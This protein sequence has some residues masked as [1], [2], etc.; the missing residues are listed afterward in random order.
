VANT[1][2]PDASYRPREVKEIIGVDN[3]DTVYGMLASGQLRGFR[4]G[5]GKAWRIAA[6]ALDEYMA[7]TAKPLVDP[8][9]AEIIA[10][11]PPLTD[12]QVDAIV[13]IIQADRS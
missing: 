3:I 4:I 12:E 13:A 9:I 10:A 11:A 7:G 2:R 5:K 8:Y 1:K 6:D